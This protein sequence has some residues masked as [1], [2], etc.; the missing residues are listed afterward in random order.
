MVILVCFVVGES[1]FETLVFCRLHVTI[2]SE[3]VVAHHEMS[4]CHRVKSTCINPFDGITSTK[5][6]NIKLKQTRRSCFF[7]AWVLQLQGPTDPL[8]TTKTR[9]ANDMP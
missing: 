8:L 6:L 9:P 3:S 4:V 5:K 1:E 2:V 7:S